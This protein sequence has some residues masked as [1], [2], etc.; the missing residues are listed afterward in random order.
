MMMLRRPY[1]AKMAMVAAS[2]AAFAAGGH[3][4]AT[5]AISHQQSKQLEE[6][7]RIALRR[8]EVAVDFGVA[9]LDDVIKRGRMNCDSASLQAVRLQVYQRS[10]V[11]DIRLVNQEGSVIC[12]AYSETLEFDNEWVTRP[13]MLRTSAHGV[14]LFRVDQINGV[15]LGVLRDIDDKTSLVAILGVSSSL[16]DIMPAELRDH[17]EVVAQLDS[18]ADI[19]RF[20]PPAGANLANAVAFTSES[21]RYPLRATVHVASEA[22]QRWNKEGY[23]PAM[24]IAAAL[25]MMFGLLLTRTVTRL[26]GPIADIDRGLSRREFRPYFQPTFDLRT[27]AI[28]GCEVLARWVHGDGTITPPM[29]FIP[30]AESSGRIEAITWQLLGVAL[31]DM[32]PGLPP[33]SISRCRSTSPRAI[34]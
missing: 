18:G 3:F 8:S 5:T 1:F 12:S 22:L 25:G 19:G 24:L 23:W 29:K 33:T 34:S 30:L 32:R 28:K 15:A 2:M 4:V 6:L 20:A 16:F 13:Q 31:K 9:T 7:A 17:G 10:A 27:G 21:H 14:L 11:K 26:E